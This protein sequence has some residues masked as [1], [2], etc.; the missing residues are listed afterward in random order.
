MSNIPPVL[1]E[2]ADALASALEA[3]PRDVVGVDTEFVWEKTYYP[4]LGLIQLGFEDGTVL[5]VDMPALD[6]P[7]PLAD[8][9]R[10]PSVVSVLHDARQDLEI[11]H[12]ATGAVPARGRDGGVSR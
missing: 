7:A 3:V 8:F 4:R 2:T 11:I 10:D 6:D 1:I 9:L 5:L 12:R